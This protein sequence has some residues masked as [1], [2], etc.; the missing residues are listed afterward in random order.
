MGIH[1]LKIHMYPLITLFHISKTY[2]SSM[3]DILSMCLLKFTS[4]A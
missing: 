3:N 4:G 1:P 2:L